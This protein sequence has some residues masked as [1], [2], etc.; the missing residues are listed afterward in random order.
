MQRVETIEINHMKNE[1]GQKEVPRKNERRKRRHSWP[2]LDT[3][4]EEAVLDHLF[5]PLLPEKHKI[6]KKAKKEEWD[7]QLWK[8]YICPNE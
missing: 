6:P 8:K 2:S 4:R 5:L 3:M 7:G 1:L